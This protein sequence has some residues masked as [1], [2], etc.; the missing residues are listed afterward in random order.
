M[1][2]APSDTSDRS[3]I[4]TGG[5]FPPEKTGAEH[6]TFSQVSYENPESVRHLLLEDEAAGSPA[7]GLPER[8]PAT[9]AFSTLAYLGRWGAVCTPAGAGF[10]VD[11]SAMPEKDREGAERMLSAPGC[12]GKTLAALWA[13]DRAVVEVLQ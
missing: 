9:G 4:K 2:V 10:S 12:R 11:L 3:D 8:D 13:G 5:S 6:T 7:P 1:P